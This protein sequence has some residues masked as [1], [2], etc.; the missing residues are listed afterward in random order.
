MIRTG[1]EVKPGK[2]VH[3]RVRQ[4][5]LRSRSAQSPWTRMLVIFVFFFT[6]DDNYDNN[7]K[8]NRFAAIDNN[9]L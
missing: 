4:K 9:E 1:C 8:N 7:I 3:R 6:D 5:I 2:T